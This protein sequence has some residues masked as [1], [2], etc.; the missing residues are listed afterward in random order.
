MTTILVVDDDSVDQELA[1][2]CLRSLDG[3][4]VSFASDGETALDLVR[5][6]QPD[7]VLT[8]LRMP[9]MDGVELVE[10]LSADF[11]LVPV[12]LMT[13]QGNELVAVRALQAGAASYV[14]KRDLKE[15]LADTVEQILMVAEARRS[16]ADI[17][18]FLDRFE[19]HFELANDP[20]LITP[21]VACVEDNL[22]RLGFG[23]AAIRTQIG[24]ALM[25]ALSNAM[26]HGNLEIGSELRRTDRD[27]FDALVAERRSSEPYVSRRVRYS[28]KESPDRVEYTIA[29]EGPGFDPADLPDPSDPANLLAVDGRGVMLMKNFMDEVRFS[30]DGASVTMVRKAP[31]G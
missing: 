26:L 16:R 17:L 15:T 30:E 25:E 28:A 22:E 19:T 27:A 18:R 1:E 3:I 13:S 2:R 20:E 9:G 23:N 4:E 7:L 10:H 6:R 12:I 11:P 14:P 21:V 8:D 31:D 24:S 5:D 29:D